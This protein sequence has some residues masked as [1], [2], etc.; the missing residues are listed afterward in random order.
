MMN[1]EHNSWVLG[2]TDILLDGRNISFEKIINTFDLIALKYWHK[3]LIYPLK[4]TLK[5][6]LIHLIVN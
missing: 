6:N 1:K 4:I 2:I 3:S 5:G